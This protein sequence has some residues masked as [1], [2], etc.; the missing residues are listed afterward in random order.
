MIRSIKDP[1]EITCF[2]KHCKNALKTFTYFEKRPVSVIKSH[3]LTLL[4]YNDKIPIG[5][6]HL[7]EEDNVV[8][9]GICVADHCQGQGIGKSIM[10]ELL[11]KADEK[12]L[13]ITLSVDRS[14]MTAINLYAQMGF[15]VF[16]EK[17]E[18]LFMRRKHG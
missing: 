14:N 2:L 15:T 12:G 4:V 11:S 7:E 1:A 8:W 16:K 3:L 9:L 13:D 6:G 17:Q 5:Y 18:N 10:D